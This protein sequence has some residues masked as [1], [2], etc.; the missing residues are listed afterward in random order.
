MI[1]NYSELELL[2]ELIWCLEYSESW[3]RVGYQSND[4]ADWIAIRANQVRVIGT[5]CVLCERRSYLP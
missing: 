4:C 5:A 2:E 3:W 1:V